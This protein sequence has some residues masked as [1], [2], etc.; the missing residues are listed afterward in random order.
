MLCIFLDISFPLSKKA[1]KSYLPKQILHHFAMA[2]NMDEDQS[3][4]NMVD[5]FPKFV[6]PRVIVQ[7]LDSPTSATDNDVSVKSSSHSDHDYFTALCAVETCR[8]LIYCLREQNRQRY[9]RLDTDKIT[10][11]QTLGETLYELY[12]KLDA[13]LQS[14]LVRMK[15]N[16]NIP[17]IEKFLDA[18]DA[19]DGQKQIFR[20][21]LW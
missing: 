3:D 13:K 8:A 14:L 5:E 18:L 11:C 10:K 20:Y 1:G 2:S 17:L 4:A 12:N 21:I 6:L 7:F 9:F 19:T 16:G 15:S